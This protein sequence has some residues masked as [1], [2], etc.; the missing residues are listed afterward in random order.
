MKK[1]IFAMLSFSLLASCAA[2]TTKSKGV[3]ISG[4]DYDTDGGADAYS[5]AGDDS[6]SPYYTNPDFYNMASNDHLTIL[7]KYA[8]FIQTTEYTCGPASALTVLYH[9]GITRYTEWDLAVGMHT[10][11]DE[12]ASGEPGTADEFGEYGT[13]VGKMYNFFSMVSDIKIVES[14]YVTSYSDDELIAAD[15]SYTSA[16]VG[17]LPPT[18]ADWALYASGLD[19]NG[20]PLWVDDAADSL[21]VSW[22]TTH[23]AGN[24]PIMVEWGDWDGHWQAIIGYDT[25]GTSDAGDDI[26]IFADPYD[27]SDQWQDGYYYYPAERFFYMWQD[28][29]VAPKPFQLQPYMIIDLND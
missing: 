26:I 5:N 12:Q 20:D 10:S 2:S 6:D 25:M 29:N 11:V 23:L 3:M 27:T 18:F 4:S 16:D 9:Y 21:F 22:V 13:S 1:V 7:S 17:N 28:R 19:A 8:T 15:G 14:S 24:Q